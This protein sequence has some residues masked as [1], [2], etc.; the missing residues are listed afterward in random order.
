MKARVFLSCGQN[1][2]S[3]EPAIAEKIAQRIFDLGFDCYM[4]VTEQSLRGL[5]ENIFAQ[6]ESSDYLVFIDFK[7]EELKTDGG[8]PVHRGSLFSHQE[9]GIASFL[10]IPALIMQERGLKP[11]DGMLGAMQANAIEFSDRNLLPNVVADLI[12]GK[13]RNGE[14]RN[15]TRSSLSL[16]VAVPPFTDALQNIGVM[17]RFYH[18]AVRNNHHRKAALYCY[19]HLDA[20]LNLGTNKLSRP[21][22]VEFKWAGTPLP[23]VRIG[24]NTIREFDGVDFIL[25]NPIQPKFWPITDSPD[26]LPRLDG[27]GKYRLSFSVVSQNFGATTTDFLLEYGTTPESVVFSKA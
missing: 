3:E 19:A 7:R 2:R 4:A 8:S 14:W 24:P 12:A 23:G 18:I 21:R 27:P 9:L 26:Y 20:V 16:E 10:E 6:L 1:K 5:R 15:N 22:T 11:L 17:R 13:L 25:A